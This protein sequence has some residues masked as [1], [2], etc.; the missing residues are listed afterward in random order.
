MGGEGEAHRTA[1]GLGEALGDLRG[2]L[3]AEHLVGPDVV[4]DL[5]EAVGLSGL[6]AGTGDARRGIDD[7]RLL[8]EKPR[9]EQRHQGQ[10][11]GGGVTAGVGHQ[12][13]PGDCRAVAQLGQAI[14]CQGEERR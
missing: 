7:D 9:P 11:G 12:A 4:G 6:P 2:V 1:G 5:A 10:G 3:V 13:A 8:G 14:G